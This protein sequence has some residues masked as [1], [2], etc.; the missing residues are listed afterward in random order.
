MLCV[1]FCQFFISNYFCFANFVSLKKLKRTKKLNL[2]INYYTNLFRL[3][4]YLMCTV[5]MH[6]R[7]YNTLQGKCFSYKNVSIIAIFSTE[8]NRR[9]FK[10]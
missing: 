4:F 5:F 3:Q 8:E 2:Q 10:I 9:V 1:P 6:N 7:I